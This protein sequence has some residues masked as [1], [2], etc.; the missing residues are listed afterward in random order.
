MSASGPAAY[1]LEHQARCVA[2]FY[3]GGRPEGIHRF[4]AGT[5]SSSGPNKLHV[6][7]Y[8]EATRTIECSAVWNHDGEVWGLWTSPS[9]SSDS[10]LFATY[11]PMDDQCR[12]Y[13]VRPSGIELRDCSVL[14]S[15][16]VGT[17]QV[18]WDREGLQVEVRTASARDISVYRL[19]TLASPGTQPVARYSIPS[20]TSSVVTVVADPHRAH[21]TAAATDNNV[22]LCD[23]RAKKIVNTN[24]VVDASLGSS[25][26]GLD[27]SP[28][29]ADRMITACSDGTLLLWDMR[30]PSTPIALHVHQHHCLGAAFHP[31]HDQLVL[32]WSSDHTVKVLDTQ[33]Y[34]NINQAGVASPAGLQPLPQQRHVWG[35]Q[36]EKTI[37]D[38][39][40]SVYS[41]SWSNSGTWI[42]A[43][44]SFHGKV[45]VD[46]VPHDT[47][48]RVLLS[49][50]SGG[51]G[52][53]EEF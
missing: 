4:I 17:R 22:F 44:V 42:F 24:M 51:G 10:S 23:T 6:I 32:S 43:G 12:I 5:A 41:A 36:P 49:K 19:E 28:A 45:L 34:Y 50:G 52:T 11:T 3:Q 46:T 33:E 29:T 15:L 35:V 37:A 14:A 16:P 18:V 48:M 7:D 1:G 13:Q 21:V 8:H 2:P 9:L 39:G 27:M 31:Y 25:I 38:F 53:S 20:S 47:K 30:Q 40:D 26:R